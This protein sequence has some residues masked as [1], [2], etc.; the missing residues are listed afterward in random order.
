MSERIQLARGRDRIRLTVMNTSSRVIR[1]SSHFPFWR[2]NGRL[3]FDRTAA[4]GF[5][6][7]LPAGATVRFAPGEEKDVTLVRFAGRGG[8]DG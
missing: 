2:T 7:D 6:L 3:R 1:V 5:R 4:Q 8:I